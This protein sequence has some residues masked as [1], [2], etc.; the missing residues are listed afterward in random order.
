MIKISIEKRQRKIAKLDAFN[1]ILEYFVSAQEASNKTGLQ[2]P[3]ICR[4]AN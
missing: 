1:N 4:C 3:D 2:Q